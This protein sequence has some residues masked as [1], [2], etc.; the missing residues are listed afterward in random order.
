MRASKDNLSNL[1]VKP[2]CLSVSGVYRNYCPSYFY[3]NPIS[4]Y[5]QRI[6]IYKFDFAQITG[7]VLSLEL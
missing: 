5:L 4:E 3:M 1:E 2:F 7:S 6:V